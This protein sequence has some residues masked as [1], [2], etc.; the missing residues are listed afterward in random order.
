LHLFYIS[1]K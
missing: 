1:L